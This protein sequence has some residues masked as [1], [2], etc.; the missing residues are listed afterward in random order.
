MQVAAA[1]HVAPSPR[2]RT[3]PARAAELPRANRVIHIPDFE[4]GDELTSEQV[5]FLETYGF[6]RF[7]RFVPRQRAQA[8]YGAVLEIDRRL[9]AEGREQING[10]PLIFGQRSDGG[11]YV[12]RI[13]FAS[14]QHEA[15]HEL[16]QDRRFRAITAAAGSDYRI[17]EDERDGLVINRFRNEPGAR[18]K[19]LGWHTDSLR[20]LFY[21]EKP[22]RYLNVGF[23]LTDSPLEVGGLRVL[24]C[25]HN[26]PISSML[27]RKA[28]FL[29][30]EP[31]PEEMAITAEA[32]DLTIHDGRLWHR[33]ALAT[34]EGDASER[35]V[36][37]LP[38]MNGPYKRKHERSSTPFY[39]RLKGLVGY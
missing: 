38:L 12:Q 25:T 21:F 39:F 7:R 16:L 31:D 2:P 24:P 18:Y 8:L 10:V 22:R 9:V 36:S 17:G 6:I 26:Q 3:T 13:P 15:F 29:D 20:D 35:C 4:L 37:Y 33:T 5:D 23:Y 1:S 27:T 32:G 30:A 14:L 11:R 19:R 28:H 34:V